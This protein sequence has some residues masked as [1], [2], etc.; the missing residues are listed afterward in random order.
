[1]STAEKVKKEVRDATEAAARVVQESKERANAAAA[2]KNPEP[3]E[4]VVKH[5]LDK[6]CSGV[7]DLIRAAEAALA[8]PVEGIVAATTAA[9]PTDALTESGVYNAPLT[10]GHELPRGYARPKLVGALVFGNRS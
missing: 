1:M 2:K 5:Q 3:V 10:I 7:A 9:K 4:A 8:K 6:L